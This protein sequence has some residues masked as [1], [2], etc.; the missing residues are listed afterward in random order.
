MEDGEELPPTQSA[1]AT[2]P[3]RNNPVEGVNLPDTPSASPEPEP[4]I[5]LKPLP[6]PPPRAKLFTN[7]TSA[8]GSRIA[9]VD[10]LREIGLILREH[11]IFSTIESLR[12]LMRDISKQRWTHLLFYWARPDPAVWDMPSTYYG[13]D[14]VK[15]SESKDHWSKELYHKFEI[16]DVMSKVVLEYATI[17]AQTE[18]GELED[19][20]VDDVAVVEEVEAFLM[21]LHERGNEVAEAKTLTVKEWE[22][23]GMME[24]LMMN[25]IACEVSEVVEDVAL[26][27]EVA[28]EAVSGE[29]ML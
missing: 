27:G 8:E 9:T 23:P 14:S 11:D 5:R 28:Y 1:D 24:T 29:S 17:A 4:R 7:T 22:R 18:D 19:Y 21:Y 6:A 20:I 13:A 26:N 12:D 10:R 16:L 2:K 3:K 15:R 25:G